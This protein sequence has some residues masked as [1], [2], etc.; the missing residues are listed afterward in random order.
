MASPTTTPLPAWA[1]RAFAAPNAVYDRGLGRLLG[2][3]FL[4]LVHTG[5]RTG[6][7]HR[8]VLEVLS[9]DARTGE[10]VV[11]A[12]MGPNAD[13]LRNLRAGRA[14]WVSFGRGPR[15]ATWRAVGDQE[16]IDILRAYEQRYGPLRP[17]LRRLLRDLAG[18]DYRDTDEAR[19]RLPHRLPLVALR[20]SVHTPDGSPRT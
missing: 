2:H 9:Y 3:R 10:A 20:P 15:P 13:W 5:R 1:R 12:G 14:A 11:I 19:R 18:F 16:A 4:Q 17:M 6:V 7:R 8:A